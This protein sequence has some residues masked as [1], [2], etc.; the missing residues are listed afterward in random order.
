VNL[1]G[2]EAVPWLDTV[3]VTELAGAVLHVQMEYVISPPGH[4]F[5]LFRAIC[6]TTQMTPGVCDGVGLGELDPE[7]VGVLVM[8]GVWLGVGE[9][10][11]CDGLGVDDG[12]LVSPRRARPRVWAVLA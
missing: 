4:A 5:D 12:L 11:L 7:A 9:P 6:A 1:G 3:T 8:L 2:P 10:V